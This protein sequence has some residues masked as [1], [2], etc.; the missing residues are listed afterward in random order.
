MN[1]HRGF[2][3]IWRKTIDWEWYDDANTFKVF[4]HLLLKANYKDKKWRGNIIK[5]GEFLTS[6]NS[7]SSETKIPTQKIRTSINRLKSTGEITCKPTNKNTLITLCN[8]EVY[9]NSETENNTQDNTQDNKQLTNK[10]Q[11][12]NKQLTTTKNVKERKE[13]KE[14]K[15][16]NKRYIVPLNCNLCLTHYFLKRILE[17]MQIV[18]NETK[19]KNWSEE[20]RKI[21][22]VDKRSVKDI[23][24]IIKDCHDMIPNQSGFT[25]AKNILSPATLRE[26]W[27][28][29]KIYIGMNGKFDTN[30]STSHEERL[31]FNRSLVEEC[32]EQ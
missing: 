11:T 2:I 18:V 23:Y 21:R 15:E 1:M 12:T 7:L 24:E 17:K 4:I 28:E 8:Y 14:C 22:S 9:N 13:R 5:R 31:K 3:K 6:L 26:K 20:F 30:K 10:Q 16:D 32:N 29:G 27:N 19:V 25:W